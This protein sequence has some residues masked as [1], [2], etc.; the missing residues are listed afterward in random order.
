MTD[1]KQKV[2]VL[3]N[4]KSGF[5]WTLDD[6]IHSVEK[7]WNVDD[8]DLTY[9]VSKSKEDGEA[10]VKRAIEQG[11]DV[12]MVVGGDGMV[13][14][15]GG[16]LIGSQ[17]AL[18]VIPAGSGNGFARHFN[19]PGDPDKAAASLRKA[20]RKTIDVGYANGHPFFVTCGFAWDADVARQFSKT[21][22]RG[23]FPY[24]LAGIYGYFTY[25][26][27]KF[28][29]ELDGKP[30]TVDKP[31]IL[32]IANLTQFGAGAQIA[33]DARPDDDLLELVIVES[34]DPVQL[35]ANI[36][37]LFDGTLNRVKAIEYKRFKRMTVRRERPDPIQVDGE[38]LE[39]PKE[40]IV[41]V[42]P[43]ALQVLVPTAS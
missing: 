23:V 42:R 32:T 43:A 33:P 17:T 40:F 15:I 25:E 8:T 26:P 11:V 5:H 6:M 13:N 27:Q 34:T 37:R 31:M 21:P 22:M 30:L 29:L 28:E 35:L 14:S 4:P 1:K 36:S 20:E 18:G 41:E 39:A 7:Y 10:K 38:L 19:I 16:A 12:I 24:V 2:R 3:F 9:Q